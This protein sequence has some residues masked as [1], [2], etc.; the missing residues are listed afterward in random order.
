HFVSFLSHC[1]CASSWTLPGSERS[2]QIRAGRMMFPLLAW[3]WQLQVNAARFGPVGVLHPAPMTTESSSVAD[4]WAP[5]RRTERV[6]PSP[7]WISFSLR[8]TDDDD[9]RDRSVAPPSGG[10]S[11]KLGPGQGPR[12]TNSPARPR[13]VSRRGRRAQV[14]ALRR[15]DRAHR[16]E[17]R[18]E[19]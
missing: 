3:S 19:R 17:L 7:M 8:A 1:D 12:R 9:E 2:V 18:L 10:I 6:R 14:L 16:S 11:A 15:G 5:S 13:L 4:T